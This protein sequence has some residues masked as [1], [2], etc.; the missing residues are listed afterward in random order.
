[1]PA[2]LPPKGTALSA[3][4]PSVNGNSHVD[5]QL[6]LVDLPGEILSRILDQLQPT[7]SVTSFS[8]T[9]R[10]PEI[11]R[12]FFESRATFANVV[13]VSRLFFQLGTPYLH[14]TILLSSQT[15]V[16]QFCSM[17][18]RHP[19]RR[20]MVRSLAWVTVLSTDEPNVQP[21]MLHQYPGYEV[22][23]IA[24]DPHDFIDRWPHLPIDRVADTS[25]FLV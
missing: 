8:S 13:S 25:E 14:H 21:T 4:R 9:S 22:G 2:Q 1:M 16:L 18:A 17:I 10:R 11:S 24:V 23:S 19:Q 12:D 6:S 3:G 7:E 20:F 5:H 15:E